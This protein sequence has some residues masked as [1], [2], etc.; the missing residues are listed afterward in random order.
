MNPEDYKLLIILVTISIA[1]MAL[2]IAFRRYK[3]GKLSE[4]QLAAYSSIL[5]GLLLCGI[6]QSRDAHPFLMLAV[7][8]LGGYGFQKFGRGARQSQAVGVNNTT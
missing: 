8:M 5:I 6:L 3:S 4:D 1:G 2:I 7:Y